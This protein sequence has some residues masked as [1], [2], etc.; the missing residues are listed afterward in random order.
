MNTNPF[1]RPFS[2]N[3]PKRVDN[4][5]RTKIQ[6]EKDI[7]EDFVREVVQEEEEEDRQVSSVKKENFI[8]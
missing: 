5:N 6:L 3:I 8:E 1:K 2:Q 4:S 7:A